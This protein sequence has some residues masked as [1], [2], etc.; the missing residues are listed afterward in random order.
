ML[1]GKEK[2]DS[3]EEVFLKQ[4]LERVDSR[5]RENSLDKILEV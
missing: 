1:S 4:C 3:I 5:E 2:D